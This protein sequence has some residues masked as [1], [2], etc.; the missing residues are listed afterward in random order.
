MLGSDS[1]PLHRDSDSELERNEGGH[2][3]DDRVR[4]CYETLMVGEV[5]QVIGPLDTHD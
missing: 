3:T 4:L 2:S 1:I 5:R